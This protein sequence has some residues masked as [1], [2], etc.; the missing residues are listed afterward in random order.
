MSR[1]ELCRHWPELWPTGVGALL[2]ESAC[3]VNTGHETRVVGVGKD[4][5][6][7]VRRPGL[8]GPQCPVAYSPFRASVISSQRRGGGFHGSFNTLYNFEN[9]L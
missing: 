1:V 6:P 3:S 9:F 5:G 8:G 2:S 7:N 4:P